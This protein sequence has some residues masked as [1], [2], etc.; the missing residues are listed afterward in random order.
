MLLNKALDSMSGLI[1]MGLAHIK[2]DKYECMKST[3]MPSHMKHAGSGIQTLI[4]HHLERQVNFNAQHTSSCKIVD[5]ETQHA[6]S[7]YRALKW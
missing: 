7:I 6:K 4:S 2:F 3:Y 1:L 5:L